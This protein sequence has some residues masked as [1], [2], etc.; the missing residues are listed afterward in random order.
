MATKLKNVDNTGFSG[1]SNAQGGR[2]I[3]AD[4]TANLRKT[5]IPYLNRLSVYHTLLKM[6]RVKFFL[7]IFSW[8]TVLNLCFAFIYYSIGVY[9]LAG[10][11]PNGTRFNQFVEA[12]FFSSQTLTTVGYGHIAPVGLLA[13]TLA[14]I[15]SFLGIIMFALVTGVFYGR[16]ARPKAFLVFSEKMLVAPFKNGR[17][18]MVRLA[19]Y[20][21]NH[22]TDVDAQL[23]AAL[24]VLNNGKRETR[25]YPLTLEI[26]RI[27]SLALSWTLVHPID[28]SSPLYGFSEED[29]LENRIE[30]IV[31][32]KGFDDHFS[33]TVQQR[34]S[35]TY[36]QLA[37]GAK[38]SPMYQ[39]GES[40]SYTLLELDKVG[41]YD[42]ITLPEQPPLGAVA[43]NA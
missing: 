17:A 29:F 41:D 12:F 23:T 25:F 16:F 20:K 39:R 43:I 14:S 33:N 36:E 32:I 5:G 7:L 1:N 40:G 8:Y 35:F 9:R 6:P 42:S 19:S 3:N 2:L 4:G 30:L 10:T 37:Y 18:L 38:F 11:N 34:T 28:E 31:N 13:N 26:P 22:L 24:H 21:N 27:N 15:E